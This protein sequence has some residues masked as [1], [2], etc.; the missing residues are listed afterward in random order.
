MKQWLRRAAALWI[1]AVLLVPAAAAAPAIS[2][3]RAVVLDAATGRVLYDCHGAD[4][5]GMASTTKIMTGLIVA[6]TCTLDAPVEIPPEAVG[7]E[8]SSMSLEAGEVLRVETLLYGLMLHSGNDAAVALAVYCAGSLECFAERMNQRARE[9]GLTDTHFVN[10]HGLSAEG[11][12]ASALDLAKLAAAAM[13][14]PTFRQVVSTRTITLEGRTFTN[15]NKLLWQVEGAEGVKT[16]YTQADGR[17]LVSSAS[18]DGRRLIAVT[19]DD[20]NDWADH[21]ALLDYGF[22]AYPLQSLAEA[23]QV[24][25]DVP[26][27]GGGEAAVQAVLSE[28]AVLPVA[29]EERV[30]LCADLP[31]FVYAPVLAGDR[32]GTLRILIDG[33]ET[34]ALPLYWR[35]TVLEGA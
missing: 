33:V 17:I 30:E 14:N 21:A 16:G 3:K 22:E 26:V 11:H 15:H 28:D 5:A 10:P 12:Y 8:G 35:Y 23:G 19:M 1:A 27:I 4:R 9:L 34:A 25:G 32:A 24:L 6:E 29:A 7:V 18:R 13:E 31:P 20:G 2:A